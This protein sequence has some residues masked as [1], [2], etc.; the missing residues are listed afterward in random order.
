VFANPIW[1]PK[2]TRTFCSSGNFVPADDCTYT[3][4]TYSRPP[5]TGRVNR[6]P[7]STVELPCLS[8]F[9]VVETVGFELKLFCT[10][11]G[12]GT[13]ALRGSSSNRSLP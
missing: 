5:P 8:R 13:V 11:P 3:G 12:P 6:F 9:S 4:C 2:D 1:S 7:L 10:W